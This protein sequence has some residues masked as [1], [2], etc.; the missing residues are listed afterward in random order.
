MINRVDRYVTDKEPAAQFARSDIVVLP[1]RR[2]SSSGPLDTAMALGL[3]IVST[4]VGGIPEA[5]AGYPR[6]ILAEPTNPKSLRDAIQSA[7]RWRGQSSPR[8]DS[9]QDSAARFNELSLAVRSTS[10][11]AVQ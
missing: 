9:W 4:R 6:V 2:C 3:P 11:T 7:V 8:T 1:Y 10:S 5:V